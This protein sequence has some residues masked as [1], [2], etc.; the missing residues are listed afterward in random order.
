[1]KPA[2]TDALGAK[3]AALRKALAALGSPAKAAAA[4]RFFK[5]GPG[6]YGEGDRFL[7]VTVPEQR[8]LTAHYLDLPL[9]DLRGL[10]RSPIHEERLSA[11]LILVKRFSREDEAGRES[12]LRLYLGNSRF[13]NNW[14]LVDQSAHEIVGA[15]FLDKDRA[16]LY[17]LIESPMLWERRIAIVATYRFIR[18]GESKDVQALAARLFR[19]P[20]DLMH[21]A[22]GWMLREMGK[23]V[24]VEDLRAFLGRHAPA[25]PRT[26]LRYAI[27]RLP[28][29]ERKRWLSIKA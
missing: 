14:D 10:L 3:A 17:R 25:M 26:M 5:T 12:I 1:M 19:D 9:R 22:G 2:K 27:E 28:Q 11:L 6:Q 7:G 16:P 23:R 8:A 29:A 21:K 18:A 4:A 20:E 13:V 24:S 15:W